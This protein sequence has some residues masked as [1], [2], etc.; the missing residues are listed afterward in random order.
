[1]VS[2]G[3]ESVEVMCVSGEKLIMN[4]F[5][6]L[7]VHSTCVLTRNDLSLTLKTMGER[8]FWEITKYVGWLELVP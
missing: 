4:G 3:Y 2:E 1:M 5:L 7:D 8:C 6:T